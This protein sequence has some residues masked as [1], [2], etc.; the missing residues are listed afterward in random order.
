MRAIGRDTSKV[1]IMYGIGGERHIA[2]WEVP[3]LPG[4]E[5]SARSGLGTREHQNQQDIF[6]EIAAALAH[7]REAGVPCQQEASELQRDLTEFLAKTG[8]SRSGM[9]ESRDKPQR[10]T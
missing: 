5:K 10:Y 7:A 9:W 3:W 6:G 1:Q 4:Y 2:D 8:G